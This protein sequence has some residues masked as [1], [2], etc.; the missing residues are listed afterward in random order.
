[1]KLRNLTSIAAALLLVAPL[2][3]L[4]TACGGGGPAAA[5]PTA[6]TLPTAGSSP[7]PSTSQPVT[8]IVSA[9]ASM[10]DALKEAK[11]EYE[12]STKGIAISFN[13]GSSGTLQKQIEQGAPADLF[14]SAA[15]GPMDSLVTKGLVGEARI[16]ARNQLVLIRPMVG[17]EVVT[18]WRDVAS[19]AVTKIA[20]ADPQHVPAGQYG[21]A[22]LQNLSLWDSVSSRLVLGE[23]VRQV[24]NY[25][26][27]GE[28]QAGIV[29]ETDA[30]I[31]QKVT[32]VA[33]APEGKYPPVIYPMA[34]VKE[35]KQAAQAQAFADFLLSEQGRRIFKKY[36]FGAGN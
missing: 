18:E 24:L 19:D 28:V 11:A 6:G 22:V 8:I 33:T 23:D 2:L 34:V 5:N 32:L 4:L 9:A 35:S 21:K 14:I 1:M 36:G 26:E 20:I 13:F 25:V 17:P 15:S 31:S 30:A 10:A 27:S 29:Y 7:S 16:V 12:A 3:T